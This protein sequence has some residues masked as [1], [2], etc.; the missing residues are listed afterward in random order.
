MK[1]KNFAK[2]LREV[3]P[4]YD[5][6]ISD[7]EGNIVKIYQDSIVE[8]EDNNDLLDFDSACEDLQNMIEDF[9]NLEERVDAIEEKVGGIDKVLKE[10]YD[11]VCAAEKKTSKSKSK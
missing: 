7:R 9:E 11:I 3:D 2:K 6:I 10:I 1:V 8:D 4:N 5:L